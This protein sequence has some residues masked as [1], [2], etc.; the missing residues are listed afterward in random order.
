MSGTNVLLAGIGFAFGALVT[1]VLLLSL[2][3]R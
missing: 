2:R 3:G 1:E